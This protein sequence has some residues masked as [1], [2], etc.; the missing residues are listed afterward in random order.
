MK[1]LIVA[2]IV[3]VNTPVYAKQTCVIV[4]AKDR[5]STAEIYQHELAHCNGWEHPDQNHKGKPRKGYQSP[6][7]PERFVRPYSGKFVDHWMTTKEAL[8][9]CSS[10]G[11]QWFE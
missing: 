11:C 2:A 1:I 8:A 5:A 10:Y 4:V 3:L 6:K 9:I 7:P